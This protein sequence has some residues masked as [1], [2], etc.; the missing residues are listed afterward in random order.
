MENVDHAPL[1][2]TIAVT[3]R[4]GY[5]EK[6]IILKKQMEPEWNHMD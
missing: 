3:T 4:I 1:S 2:E 6:C 5:V